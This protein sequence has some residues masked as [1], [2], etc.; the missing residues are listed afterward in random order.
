MLFAFRTGYELN[1][2]RA[3]LAQNILDDEDVPRENFQVDLVLVTQ[4]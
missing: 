1:L 3:I 4:E 2:A